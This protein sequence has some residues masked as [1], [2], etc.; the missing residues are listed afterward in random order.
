MKKGSD[1]FF[2]GAINIK[3]KL[4]AIGKRA[5]QREKK[6]IN[7]SASSLRTS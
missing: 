3:V 7:S 4:L 5:T 1:F 6:Q 2:G